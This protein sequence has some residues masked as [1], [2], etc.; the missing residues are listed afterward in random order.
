M[1]TSKE[2]YT[3]VERW[4]NSGKTQVEFAKEINIT[5]DSFSYWVKKYRRE[6]DTNKS[7][8]LDSVS[9]KFKDKYSFIELPSEPIINPVSKTRIPQAEITLPNGVQIIIY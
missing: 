5:K 4:L 9:K 7:G 3:H 6:F 1:K 2:M 8:K